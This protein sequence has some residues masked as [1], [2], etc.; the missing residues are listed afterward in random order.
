M[1]G[2]HDDKENV[3]RSSSKKLWIGKWKAQ[4][5]QL[6]QS[7]HYKPRTGPQKRGRTSFCNERWKSETYSSL[8][9]DKGVVTMALCRQNACLRWSWNLTVRRLSPATIY[10]AQKD[11]TNLRQGLESR[12]PHSLG[13]QFH[14]RECKTY[15]LKACSIRTHCYCF[16]KWNQLRVKN[17]AYI[18]Y[19]LTPWSR[20]L[21]EN[22]TGSAASQEIP[23]SFGTRK[24]ITV[25]ISARHLS[26]SWANSIQSSQPPP[27]L[28]EDPS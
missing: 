2:R 17:K 9:V 20:V 11:G 28:P 19:L 8:V 5:L 22:L 14:V 4:L 12:V 18:T 26:L 23:R 13:F 15:T 16:G 24:F 25:L 3:R 1:G 6:I 7:R 10:P 21:L 27:P